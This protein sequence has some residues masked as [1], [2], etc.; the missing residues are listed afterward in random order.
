MFEFLLRLFGKRTDSTRIVT[1]PT[2]EPVKPPQPMPPPPPQPGHVT[3]PAA[4]SLQVERVDCIGGVPVGRI[5]GTNII[6]WLAGMAIDADGAYRA[7]DRLGRGLDYLANAGS[8]GNWYGIVTDP[9]THTPFIQKSS[10]PAPG[11]YISS[12][13][14]EDPTKET[15]DPRRYLDSESI[16]FLV[17]PGHMAGGLKMGDFCTMVNVS[18]NQVIHGLCG[19]IG[20]RS[21]IGEASIAAA[22][23]LGIPSSPK[24]GGTDSR[25]ILYIAYQGTALNPKDGAPSLDT[26]QK[27]SGAIYESLMLEQLKRRLSDV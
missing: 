11:F 12:T 27:H 18:N 25:K 17:V 6:F 26:I 20:P 19:D 4:N 15:R 22:K 24:S 9:Q 7:Y 23:G 2:P 10:D 14:W 3:P 21:K 8:P 5:V 13:A 16:P 1:V